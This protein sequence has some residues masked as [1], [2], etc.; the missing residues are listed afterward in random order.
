L[1]MNTMK[2]ILFVDDDRR[3]L[4]GLRRSLHSM[5]DE[6]QM[7]FT[8]NAKDALQA[9]DSEPIDAVVTDMRMPGITGL[10]LL[11]QTSKAWPQVVR[12]I[13]SGQIEERD[14]MLSMASTHFVLAKP[15]DTEVLKK[16]IRRAMSHGEKI[17][18]GSL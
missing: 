18:D 13:L 4:D 3:V 10:Q 11:D 17:R 15:C 16:R 6:W 9:L 14:V 1:E 2:R 5:E 8:R 12:I 7:E